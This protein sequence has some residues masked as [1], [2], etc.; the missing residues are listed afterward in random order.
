MAA[1]SSTVSF[2]GL[3]SGI[4]LSFSFAM[5][6]ASCAVRFEDKVVRDH[7][8]H[9]KTWPDGDGRLDVERTA[10]HLLAGLIDALRYALLNGLGERAV[11]VAAHAGLRSDAEQRG[12]NRR[13]EQRAPMVVDLVLEAGIALRVGAGLTL[14]NDRAA[15]RHDQAIPDEERTCLPKGDLRI[16]LAD[17]ARALRDQKDLARWAVIDV[18]RHLCGHLTGQVGAQAGDQCGG[19]YRTRLQN[20]FARRRLNAVRACGASVHSAIEKGELVILRSEIGRSAVWPCGRLRGG[21]CR[22]NGG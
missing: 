2:T 14:Q 21:W 7:H 20:V 16:V 17:E 8:A 15:V 19:D 4:V 9:R 22:C 6:V 18:F 11:V 5:I 12:E 10:D 1:G 3:S 13:L